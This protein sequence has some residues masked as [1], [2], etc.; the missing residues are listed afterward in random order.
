MNK[1]PFKAKKFW[2]D[3]WYLTSHT[4][5]SYFASSGLI[6]L[7]LIRR[8]KLPCAN[9]QIASKTLSQSRLPAKHRPKLSSWQ[10]SEQ[11]LMP[12]NIFRNPAV[13]IQSISW[14][15][16][17]SHYHCGHGEKTCCLM[18]GRGV[19]GDNCGPVIKRRNG[20][21]WAGPVATNPW[22]SCLCH[23]RPMGD[24]FRCQQPIAESFISPPYIEYSAL[25]V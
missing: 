12:T 13:N 3:I 18:P 25:E 24:G 5:P 23:H 10:T 2:Q 1:I 11:Q 19:G 4:G 8:T 15:H 7:K 20:R 16:A 21:Q 22:G 17:M 14:F 6:H 9:S